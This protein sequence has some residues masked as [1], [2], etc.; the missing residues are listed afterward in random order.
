LLITNNNNTSFRNKISSKFTLK[1]N[2]VKT[3][4]SKSSKDINKPAIFNKL[5]S[6]ILAKSFKKVNEI[7]KFFKKNIQKNEKKD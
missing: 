4:K 3:N 1:V 6:S 2:K 7:L 5:P